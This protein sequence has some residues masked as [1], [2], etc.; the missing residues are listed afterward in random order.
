MPTNLNHQYTS[1]LEHPGAN[2]S[3]FC[4]TF[5]EV[6]WIQFVQLTFQQV[7]YLQ[8]CWSSKPS[9]RQNRLWIIPKAEVF[10]AFWWDSFP[11]LTSHSILHL[12]STWVKHC[13]CL[14]DH[15]RTCKWLVTPS[16]SRGKAVGKGVPQNDPCRTYHKHGS[17]KARIRKSWDDASKVYGIQDTVFSIAVS[18]SLNRW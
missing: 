18:G 3:W 10:W 7:S 12:P 4:L 14:E 9:S 2:K 13:L 1:H 16:I 8:K 17:E 5:I 6:P 11:F 15:P